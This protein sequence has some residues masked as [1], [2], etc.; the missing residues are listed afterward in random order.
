MTF[1]FI[2]LAIRREGKEKGPFSFGPQA[3]VDAMRIRATV[4]DT[5][6]P[7]SLSPFPVPL[8]EGK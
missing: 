7:F 2:L 8:K 4:T 3:M 6:I 1:L 5:P